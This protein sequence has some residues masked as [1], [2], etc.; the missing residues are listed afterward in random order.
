[1]VAASWLRELRSQELKMNAIALRPIILVIILF[2]YENRNIEIKVVVT[3][4]VF[5]VPNFIYMRGFVDNAVQDGD[6]HSPFQ[7]L[8][9]VFFEL[10]NYT[11]GDATEALESLTHIDRKYPLTTSDYGIGDFIEDLK[12]NGYI[13]ENEQT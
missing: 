7:K 6:E 9:D 11:S 3:I 4:E 12:K 5:L 13:K 2:F 1:L 8:L 10:L